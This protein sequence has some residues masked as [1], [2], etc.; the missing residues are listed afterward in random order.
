MVL[1]RNL[2]FAVIFCVLSIIAG[3]L[4]SQ[5]SDTRNSNAHNLSLHDHESKFTSN[6]L[7]TKNRDKLVV[8]IEDHTKTFDADKLLIK[9]EKTIQKAKGT[10]D[11]TNAGL[12]AFDI[13]LK[14]NCSFD[15]ILMEKNQSHPVYGSGTPR[16]MENASQEILGIFIV[17]QGII[18]K[19]FKDAPTRWSPD[20][21]SHFR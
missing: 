5:L 16:F 3:F 14:Q 9:L 4:Y 8:C 12:T 7:L 1:K 11:W 19:H 17:D 20:V 6:A 21:I 13:N 15:P 2:L 18:D 10:K